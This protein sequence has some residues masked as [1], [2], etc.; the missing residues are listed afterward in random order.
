MS[1]LRHCPYHH[2]MVA[3]GAEMVDRLNMAA[4]LRYTST[5][6]EHRATRE[7]VGL[8]DVYCQFGVEV[9]GGQALDLLQRVC[10]N[11][12]SRLADGTALYSSLCNEN[13]GMIDDLTVF[14]LA[15]DRYWLFPT[16]ARVD[17]VCDWVSHQAKDM[18]AWLTNLGYKSAYISIQGPKSRN[19]LEK[20]TDANLATDSLPYY[21]FTWTSVADVPGTMLSRTGY[22]GELGYELFYPSEYA[23]HMWD[24]LLSAGQEFGIKPCGLGALRTLRM[25]KRYPLYGL[26]IDE[27]TTPL[28]AGLDWTVA[29]DKGDFIGRAALLKQ[30]EEGVPRRLVLVE[31]AGLAADVAIGDAVSWD[32]AEVGKVRSAE[33]GYTLQS[34]L[35][36]TYAPTKAAVDSTEVTITTQDGASHAGKICIAPP[37]DPDRSR[38]KV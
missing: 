29:F 10:V 24:A 19:T 14:R 26:D 23:E 8:F 30:M 27:N 20:L 33:N 9:V 7:A 37:Y 22:S 11:D 21:S 31:I 17:A 28:E 4:P 5:E 16:P 2:K 36:M 12:I 32:G 3:L 25:E 1:M 34:T 6:E 15:H 35:A 38:I 13:G 18:A